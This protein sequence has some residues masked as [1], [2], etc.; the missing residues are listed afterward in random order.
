MTVRAVLRLIPLV[1]GLLLG[2]PP[3]GAAGQVDPFLDDDDVLPGSC[4]PDRVL[5]GQRV[6]C[7]FPL[8]RP[9]PLDPV[10]GPYVADVD[11]GYDE[12]ED[13][14][15]D[16]FV[17]GD[18]LVCRNVPTGFYASDYGV[19][20]S[21]GWEGPGPVLATATA[22]EWSA[23]RA[24]FTTVT[25]SEPYAAPGRPL[26]IWVDAWDADRVAVR[27]FPRDGGAP[28]ATLPI[29][30]A[31]DGEA[32]EVDVSGLE[33]GRYRIQP[34]VGPDPCEEVPGA[35]YVQVG[36]GR[37]TEAVPGRNRMGADRINLVLAGT[38]FPDQD[39]FRETA[40]AL[41]GLDGPLPLDGE[42][43]QMDG[44]GEPVSVEWGPFAGEPLRSHVDRF[45]LWLLAEPVADHH[46][47]FWDDEDVGAGLGPTGSLPDAQVTV[48]HLMPPGRWFT[49]EANWSSFTGIGAGLP[50]RE[51]ID[52]AGTYVALPAWGPLTEADTLTHELGHS[53]FDLRD[54]YTAYDREVQHGY[55]NC[56]PD[57]ETA[58]E[59]WGDL[60][61]GVDPFVYEYAEVMEGL[62][63][64][65]PADLVANIT[66]GFEMGGCY[67]AEGVAGAVRPTGES[68]MRNQL[69]V[70]GAVNRERAEKILALWSGREELVAAA[71]LRLDCSRDAR[72]PWS[73][74][75]AG[76]LAPYVDM[77]SDG[78]M[79]EAGGVES[80]CLA[81]P[82][83]GADPVVVECGPVEVDGIGQVEVEIG[84]G[85]G[86]LLKTALVDPVDAGPVALGSGWSGE[87]PRA[88]PGSG[89]AWPIWSVSLTA[90]VAAAA[91]LVIVM[92]R[93][94]SSRR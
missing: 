56:A 69:P 92:R 62:G 35:A 49:S 58:E 21:F 86:P 82:A 61:G 67:G 9:L 13:E 6:D 27:F 23:A 88:E 26:A 48:L 17:E 40:V 29:G 54:E 55:P 1:L 8:G 42:G 44:G 19:R 80:L 25:G 43:E 38:G 57:L 33:P 46:A 91:G 81:G 71:D 52:F 22:I 15:P 31:E 65:V 3:S 77:P 66:V 37:L 94:G 53:L 93:R 14:Q 83:S 11:L 16:C 39:G 72:D 18:E 90:A 74:R 84:A 41:L 5:A 7:R 70:F 68:I 2:V 89:P 85:E 64:W 63:Q 78:L 51:Q 73:V 60:V 50:D 79:M 45:N 76:S 47:F 24:A 36:D 32:V 75:C 59:W 4:L 87:P 20:V 10:G 28:V 30:L 34:C 12:E